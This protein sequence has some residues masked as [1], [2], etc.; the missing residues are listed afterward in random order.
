VKVLVTGGAGYIG[1]HAVRELRDAGHDVA[2]LDDLSRGHRQ[3][4]PPEVPLVRGDLGDAASLARALTG[5][6]A[7]MH[8][9]GLLS[10]ADSV[11]DP[12]SYYRTNVVKGLALLEAMQA[13]GVRDIVFS[14]TCAVYGIPVRVPIDED[15]PKDP[16]NPY[17]A[18]KLAFERALADLSRAG[19]LRAVAL[20]YFN[21]AGCHPDGTL[22]ED[23]RPEEHL[24][25]RAIDAAL[26]R[27]EPLSIHGEDYDTPDGTCIRDYI[28]VQDLAR[29]HVLALDLVSGGPAGTGADRPAFQAF[30]L[31]TGV[32]RSV[33][34]VIQTVE[35]IARQPVPAR[36][37]P[38]RPGDPPRLVAAPE[39]GR[40]LLGFD[41]KHT[42]L[43]GIVESALRWRRDHPQGY[44]TAS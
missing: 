6:D 36:V 44:G 42:A 4:V 7:V 17:G 9:A 34:E 21:A 14:S 25:P 12:A 31:G 16:I 39:R 38:R 41:A 37:G 27:A 30:N 29:A 8:F 20:R 1:S 15:H 3:A 10:V 33:R 5:T 11:A 32:G 43:E 28:H 19:R 23:H 22:G 2:V 40:R 24:I 26:R 18:T 35:R 13:A